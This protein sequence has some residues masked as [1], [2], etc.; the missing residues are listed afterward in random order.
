MARTS[1]H[2]DP[3]SMVGRR[4]FAL[5]L[6]GAIPLA[7]VGAYAQLVD[8]LGSNALRGAGS[9]FVHPLMRAWADDYRTF[10][11]GGVSIRLAGS[12]LDDEIGGVA[13]DYEAVGS[14]AGIA[15]VKARAVDFA[16]SEMPLDKADL[17]RDGLL[18]LPLVTGAVA[19]AANIGRLVQP[20]RLSASL[21][22]DIF[23]GRVKNWSDPLIAQLNAG[24][25]LPNAP[26]AVVHRADG[27][28]TTFVFSQFLSQGSADWK[29]KVGSGLL[30]NWPV[31]EGYKGNSGVA[32]A[33]AR[34]PNA[35]AYVNQAELAPGLTTVSVQN[36]AGR[37]VA[38]ARASIQAAAASSPWDAAAG[39]NTLLVNARDDDSY[40]IVATVFGL[41]NERSTGFRRTLTRAFFEWSLQSGREQAERLGYTPLPAG[42]AQ[43]VILAMR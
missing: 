13:L 24:L 37:F 12:G 2:T 17:A 8:A 43:Q 30:I 39:F 14:Q 7:S 33:L 34:T 32:R 4:A 5:G 35:I 21:L 26:I 42:V 29:S 11:Q 25:T 31:G 20:L 41:L 19:V 1:F 36:P 15:R 38:L 40:P 6:A 27:S 3:A 28:G 22:A 10:R 16:A 18:Q 9:T 23:S